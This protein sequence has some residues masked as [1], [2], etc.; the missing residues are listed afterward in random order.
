VYGPGPREL[1][2]SVPRAVIL[3]YL[4]GGLAWG[5]QHGSE[6]YAVLNACRA[7]IF[8][9]D[10][11][12]VSKIQ[13]GSLALARGLGPPVVLSRALRQHRGEAPKKAVGQDAADYV[14][15][16][17]DEK[18]TVWVVHAGPGHPKSTD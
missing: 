17:D 16:G 13:G 15:L 11:E 3:G 6:A 8:L 2:G 5:L 10:D 12:V 1:I 9:A 18:Q 14:R 4:A 7:L